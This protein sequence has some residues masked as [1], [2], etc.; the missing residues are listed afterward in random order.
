MLDSIHGAALKADKDTARS[1]W[2]DIARPSQARSLDNGIARLWLDGRMEAALKDS[3]PQINA[4][5]AWA[6]GYDGKGTKVA[7]LDTGIDP[8]HPDVKDRILESKSFVPG[9]DVLDR[10]GHGTHVAST[11]AGS[12]AASNGVN[13]GVAPGAEAPPTPPRNNSSRAI[14]RLSSEEEEADVAER[15]SAP[16]GGVGCR[17]V[18]LARAR[19]ARRSRA[20]SS[21]LFRARSS[22]RHVEVGTVGDGCR[23]GC[24]E[25]L[26]RST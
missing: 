25:P 3:V 16:A 13:K 1:F 26:R 12:G 20:C 22:R 10:N 18:R 7:V 19:D 23:R 8:T 21:Y 2:N 5:Q 15:A 17:Y 6:E 14:N 4:P 11:I 24:G 9:Q